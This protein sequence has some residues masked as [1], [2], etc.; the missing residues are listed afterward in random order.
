MKLFNKQTI[1]LLVSVIA[2][3]IICVISVSYAYFTA[4]IKGNDKAENMV[5]KTGTMTI[6]YA[7]T[8]TNEVSLKNAIPGDSVTKQFKVENTG[9]LT[10]KYNIKLDILNTGNSFVTFEKD[11]E[12]PDQNDNTGKELA[13]TI[14]ADSNQNA[15]LVSDY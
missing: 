11:L 10:A 4:Q 15:Q 12:N 9:S 5:I 2:I 13:L 7:D 1:A 8:D 14:S 3:N 6:T